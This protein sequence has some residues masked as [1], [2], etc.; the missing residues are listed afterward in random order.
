MSPPPAGTPLAKWQLW[1]W[2]PPPPPCWRTPV[3]VSQSWISSSFPSASSPFATAKETVS[4]WNLY[5][6]MWMRR[7]WK[8]PPSSQTGSM[9]RCPRWSKRRRASEFVRRRRILDAGKKW[10]YAHEREWGGRQYLDGL[11]NFLF[12]P[13]WNLDFR[14]GSNRWSRRWDCHYSIRRVFHFHSLHVAHGLR[15]CAWDIDFV[16]TPSFWTD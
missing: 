4:T 5:S 13:G 14:A 11:W 9:G 3:P 12:L 10:G 8:V 7:M 6:E 15:T 2:I 16:T 1:P